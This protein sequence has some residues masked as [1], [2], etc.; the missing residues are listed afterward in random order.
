M[1]PY[2]DYMV[3]L[4]YSGRNE[5]KKLLMQRKESKKLALDVVNFCQVRACI[6]VA[7]SRSFAHFPFFVF[8][9]YEMRT[10]LANELTRFI[11]VS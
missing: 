5:S 6:I 2:S 7:S 1:V 8:N 9:F 3:D 10:P 11:K 4:L